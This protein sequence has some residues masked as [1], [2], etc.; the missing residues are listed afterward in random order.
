MVLFVNLSATVVAL[1]LHPTPV[2]Q[3][4][5]RSFR[6]SLVL[7]LASFFIFLC[8]AS[9]EEQDVAG[10][11][12]SKGSWIKRGKKCFQDWNCLKGTLLQLEGNDYLW[13][14]EIKPLLCLYLEKNG[15][16]EHHN[17]RV[18]LLGIASLFVK[19]IFWHLSLF[20]ASFVFVVSFFIE[21]HWYYVKAVGHSF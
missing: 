15:A 6:T 4:V 12:V 5:D 3:S 2:S 18:A 7:R 16:G 17:V 10:E 21:L 19:C 9:V 14:S 20:N 8:V 13:L 11:G 1:S